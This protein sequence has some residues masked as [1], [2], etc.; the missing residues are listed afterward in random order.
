[1]LR[2]LHQKE[3]DC[4]RWPASQ[5]TEW[6][7]CLNRR[8]TVYM[9]QSSNVF[10]V[11][12]STAK[13]TKLFS[14]SY[15]IDSQLAYHSR[16]DHLYVRICLHSVMFL[17]LPC[18]AENMAHRC[19]PLPGVQLCSDPHLPDCPFCSVS[20]NTWWGFAKQGFAQNRGLLQSTNGFAGL[21]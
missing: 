3:A 12:H 15:D 1:M 18:V 20:S 6:Y 10:G 16:H 9:H 13:Q 2:K 21:F 11:P 5:I 19:A 7:A 8:D 17:E 4:L 14:A